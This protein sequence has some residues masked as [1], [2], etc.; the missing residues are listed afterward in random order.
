MVVVVVVSPPPRA[1][2]H[3]SQRRTGAVHVDAATACLISC[4]ACHFL[5]VTMMMMLLALLMLMVL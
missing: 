1:R 3:T 4:I 2:I 5:L